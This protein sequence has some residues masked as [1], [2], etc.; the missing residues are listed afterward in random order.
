VHTRTDATVPSLAALPA[1]PGVCGRRGA[2]VVLARSCNMQ[3]AQSA[4]AVA[5]RRHCGRALRCA[6]RGRLVGTMATPRRS[7]YPA[8]AQSRSGR[9]RSCVPCRARP[10]C[11][12]TTLSLPPAAFA[13]RSAG[14]PLRARCVPRA[15]GAR[16]HTGAEAWAVDVMLPLVGAVRDASQQVLAERRAAAC[17]HT[18]RARSLPAAAGHRA[19]PKDLIGFSAGRG[20]CSV[21]V[22]AFLA[23]GRRAVGA[24]VRGAD[25][26]A[27]ARRA[28]RCGARRRLR[29]RREVGGLRGVPPADGRV[30]ARRC[31]RASR[32]CRGPSCSRSLLPHLHRNLGSPLPHLH[33]NWGSLLP[34]LHRDLGSPLPHLHR[35]RGSPLPHLHRNWVSLLPHLH[36]DRGSS[37]PHLHRD[38]GSPPATS[39]PG[40]AA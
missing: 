18:A 1:A 3:S 19:A 38:R 32:R 40:L 29:V 22:R 36:R 11:R 12:L 31:A 14:R 35:D 28:V 16:W 15:S 24:R 10:Q 17:R 30:G 7:A 27:V 20:L 9:L 21:E 2:D 23:G 39:A 8:R 25:A 34:H 4:T 5:L 26:R 37:L 6:W 13:P 33:R